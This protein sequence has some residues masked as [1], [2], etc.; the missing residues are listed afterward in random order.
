MCVCPSVKM[1]EVVSLEMDNHMLD[2]EDGCDDSTDAAFSDDEEE[3]N[4][5]GDL[6]QTN[7]FYSSSPQHYF[8]PRQMRSVTAA[9]QRVS[10]K[11]QFTLWETSFL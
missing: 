6:R 1:E 11:E 10:T 5:K 8:K 3:V 2:K 9:I 7:R 4:N